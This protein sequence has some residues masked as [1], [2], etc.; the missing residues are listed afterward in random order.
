MSWRRLLIS[1]T[2]IGSYCQRVTKSFSL[3]PN[4]SRFGLRIERM[5][6]RIGQRQELDDVP[7]RGLGQNDLIYLLGEF[8]VLLGDVVEEDVQQ[9][10]AVRVHLFVIRRGEIDVIAGPPPLIADAPPQD[11]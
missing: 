8:A 9:P 6:Y 7:D 4:G 1:F 10:G 11:E 5:D 3:R 2:R